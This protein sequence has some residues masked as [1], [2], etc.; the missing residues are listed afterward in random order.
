MA[1]DGIVTGLETVIP[2]RKAFSASAAAA[3]M[4]LAL[5]ILNRFLCSL[6]LAVISSEVTVK[7]VRTRHIKSEE[8]VP[9]PDSAALRAFACLENQ[10]G[11]LLE[12][13]PFP[14]KPLCHK[15]AESFGLVTHTD[16]VRGSQ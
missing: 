8:P 4:A 16:L 2:A 3:A 12:R 5:S 14:K 10:D 9:F 1:P 15:I 7:L 6:R 11:S 13:L